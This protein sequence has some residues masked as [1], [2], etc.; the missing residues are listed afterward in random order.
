[1]ADPLRDRQIIILPDH[2]PRATQP[3]GKPLWHPDGRPKRPGQDHAADVARKIEGVAKR[4]TILMLPN[5]P[6]KGDVSDWLA[7][8]GN[9]EELMRLA[10]EQP[11]E[12]TEQSLNRL[13]PADTDTAV[14][15]TV[16]LLLDHRGK[17]LPV[18]A[19]VATVL[20]DA[21]ELSGLFIHD[22]MAAQV[23]V[24]RT[25]SRS[26]LDQITEAR[27]LRDPDITAVQEWLQRNDL[28]RLGKDVTQQAIDLIAQEATFH[29]VREY[30][31]GLRWDRTPRFGRWLTY[32]LGCEPSEYI[33]A[34]GR[35]FFIA[36]VARIQQPGCKADYMLVLEGPQ[37]AR[38]STVCSIL[39]GVWF[40][41]NLPDLR[42]ADPVRVS[43]H[44]RG[45]WLIEVAEMSA[46]GKADAGALKAFLT[47]TEE[48]YTPKFG[49]NEVTEPRQCVF[50]GTTNKTT[51]PRDETGGRR[52]WPVVVG[53]I[54]AEAL[55]HDRDQLFAEATT[56]YTAGEKWW[57]SAE[58]EREH[59][60][61]EQ[62][63]RYEADPWEPLVEA[64]RPALELRA[65]H[66]K[67]T[68]MDI[69]REALVIDAPKLGTTETR[70][71]TAILERLGWKAKRD[72]TSRWWEPPW[73]MT[74]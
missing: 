32:Y 73:A 14:R 31:D 61:P 42:H 30:L 62:E 7:A 68:T 44:L 52:F 23:M 12:E 55:E 6:L 57:P 48:R 26:W 17:P 1:M 40:S 74:P 59:I 54:D 2:D 22:A 25:P 64:W 34:I 39:G 51:Y 60:E 53:K 20:R 71:I 41:D 15:R 43:M 45:K 11:E 13:C 28:D 58:F 47:Q 65:S 19:K 8:G 18:L 24:T 56:A 46:L 35:W 21:P 27:P 38:K 63:R 4:V 36:M 10:A 37:G 50:I 70:R 49:R 72:M 9:A 16:P 66:L 67:I 5:L 69:A 33:S 29:P 3:D